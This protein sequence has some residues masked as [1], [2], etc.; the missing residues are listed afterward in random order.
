MDNDI[1][2]IDDNC[3]AQLESGEKCQQSAAAGSIYR[4]LHK[5]PEVKWRWGE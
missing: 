4:E 2:Y 3:V 5:T 1:S